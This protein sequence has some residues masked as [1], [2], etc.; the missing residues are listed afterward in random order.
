MVESSHEGE[1]EACHCSLAIADC[2]RQIDL[3]FSLYTSRERRQSIAKADLLI[4]ILTEF[5][6]SLEAEAKLIEKKRKSIPKD[7]DIP[8]AA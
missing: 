8:G 5:R 6:D 1:F 4:R 3:E 7:P 2:R